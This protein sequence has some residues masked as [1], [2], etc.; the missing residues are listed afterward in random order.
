MNGM[1][2]QKYIFS[3]GMTHSLQLNFVK[4]LVL[5]SQRL[6]DVKESYTACLQRFGLEVW[7]NLNNII[8]VEFIPCVV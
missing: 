6:P 8:I 2:Y 7:I 1:L 3:N 4:A 5:I